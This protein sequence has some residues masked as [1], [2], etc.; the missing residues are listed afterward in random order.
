MV[1][2]SCSL[3]WPGYWMSSTSSC[4]S[5][6]MTAWTLER[7]ERQSCRPRRSRMEAPR[8]NGGGLTAARPL[9]HTGVL[10]VEPVS[11]RMW[12]A[13]CGFPCVPF[14]G[15]ALS[16]PCP[17]CMRVRHAV[18]RDSCRGGCGTSSRSAD[19]TRR[20]YACVSV[21]R[22]PLRPSSLFFRER[23]PRPRPSLAYAAVARASLFSCVIRGCRRTL[24]RSLM[25]VSLSGSAMLAVLSSAQREVRGVRVCVPLLSLSAPPLSCASVCWWRRLTEATAQARA[26]KHTRKHTYTLTHIY[27]YPRWQGAA[28]EGGQQNMRWSGAEAGLSCSLLW[29]LARVRLRVR[30]L[31]R[32]VS[33]PL[34]CAICVDG[35]VA[36]APTESS[37]LRRGKSPRRMLRHT[38]P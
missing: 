30:P 21:C 9:P 15:P 19:G 17:S 12:C 37:G 6:P 27:P 33:S 28:A 25:L 3:C 7:I 32:C 11:A 5:F 35:F 24:S 8:G 1:P 16:L 2:A 26:A 4:C 36:D 38:G 22:R 20:L 34:S 29:R 31:C 23:P 14:A 13:S 18:H 10:V